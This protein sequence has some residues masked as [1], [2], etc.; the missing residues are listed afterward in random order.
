VNSKIIPFLKSNN[1]KFKNYV[2]GFSND[3]ELINALDKKWNGALPVTFIYDT[4]G[5][6]M[7]FLQ[8]MKTYEEFKTETK[9]IITN[10]SDTK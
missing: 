9:K 5:N 6:K 2:N 10:P 3:E 4:K 8:G 1:V 7:V